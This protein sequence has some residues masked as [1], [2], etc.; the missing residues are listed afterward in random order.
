MYIYV[1]TAPLSIFTRIDVAKQKNSIS[2]VFHNSNHRY[3]QVLIKTIVILPFT[4][5]SVSLYY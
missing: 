1:N 4:D 5:L 2:L 3:C